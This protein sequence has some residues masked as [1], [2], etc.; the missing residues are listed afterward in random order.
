MN[1]VPQIAIRNK[2]LFMKHGREF[3]RIFGVDLKPYF[4]FVTGFD[5]I[6]FDEKF[7]KAPH[8][9]SMAE[10]VFEKY[11][12]EGYDLMHLLINHVPHVV[13]SAKYTKKTGKLRITF[14]EEKFTIKF[15]EED[16]WNAILLKSGVYY[17]VHLFYEDIEEKEVIT[18]SMYQVNKEGERVE[19]YIPVS[20]TIL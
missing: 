12:K 20:L 8:Y 18:V 11:G 5:I 7:V 9:Q 14:G 10:A 19:E 2:M 17:D 3:K 1:S 15:K 6:E 16:E 13:V 4:D